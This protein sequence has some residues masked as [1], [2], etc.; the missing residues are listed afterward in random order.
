MSPA[1]ATDEPAIAPAGGPSGWN[2]GGGMRVP[3][4]GPMTR[5]PAERTSIR[6]SGEPPNTTCTAPASRQSSGSADGSAIATSESP[7]PFTSPTSAISDP[8]RPNRPGATDRKPT[9]LPSASETG[10]TAVPAAAS[11]GD[12]MPTTP[13]AAAAA[14]P[15]MPERIPGC[16]SRCA[17]AARRAG[18]PALPPSRATRAARTDRRSP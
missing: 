8:V 2:T 9:K 18:A 10:S 5:N 3:W 1:P 16:I 11:G 17:R 4:R 7:S 15:A 14:D 13:S 6:L 12:T